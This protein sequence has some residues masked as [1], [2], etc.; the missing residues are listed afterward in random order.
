[1][2]PNRFERE[3]QRETETEI[4]RQRDTKRHTTVLNEPYMNYQGKRQ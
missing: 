2:F 1:M 3:R 4:Q